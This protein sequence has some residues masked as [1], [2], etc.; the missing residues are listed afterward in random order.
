M[1]SRPTQ[2]DLIDA[3][4]A[5]DA[6][7]FLRASHLLRRLLQAQPTNTNW[8]YL[9]ACA[10][11]ELGRLGEAQRVIE[12]GLAVDPTHRGLLTRLAR[13]R[14]ARQDLAGAHEA[15]DRAIASDPRESRPLSVK[16]ELLEYEGR[17]DEALALLEEGLRTRSPAYPLAIVYARVC[18]GLG[19]PE[20]ALRALEP[21]RDDDTIP[22]LA[23]R[24][25]LFQ[26]GGVL[27]RLERYDEAFRAYERANA[28]RRM[29]FDADAFERSIDLLIERWTPGAWDRSSQT[30]ERPVFI[31]GLP[32]TGTSLL[33]QMLACA[34]QVH[35]AGELPIV[36]LIAHDL[37][38][39]QVRPFDHV[40]KIDRLHP[41]LL[42]KHARRYLAEHAPTNRDAIRVTDKEPVNIEHLG[43]IASLL[44][45]AR[46]IH[47]TRDP[48]DAGLSIFFQEFTGVLPWAGDLS[49]IGRYTRCIDRLMD[50]WRRVLDL[51]VCAVRYED[52]T[53]DTEGTLRR[54][55]AHLD[56]PFCEQSLSPH[57]NRRVTFTASN[58][59]VREAI[60]TRSLARW[61]H[62]EPHIGPLREALE[63]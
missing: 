62:Y 57:E 28:L 14:M 9:L 25:L 50:H 58:Q 35:A 8:L 10:E 17:S 32:R 63:R 51:P 5:F 46:V 47:C 22:P 40:H 55:F 20:D 34:P 27:D 52:L 3:R 42:D 53:Q 31:V 49:H 48:L 23:R 12:R 24:S 11:G 4:R 1:P 6:G 38:L 15:I 41:A 16:A 13:L 43:L 61:R 59:Q 18:Q 39:S 7:D 44:P 37:A 30:S 36:R 45:H 54:V 56:L 60:H 33:E 29:D 21:L 2:Q 26:L 19:R